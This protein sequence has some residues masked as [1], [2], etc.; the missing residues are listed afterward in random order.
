VAERG[1]GARR[2]TRGA[3][4]AI[5]VVDASIWISSLVEWDEHH[6][7]CDRWLYSQLAAEEAIVLP[8]LALAEIAGAVARRTGNSERG[9]RAVM[10]VLD[11]PGVRIVDLTERL[12]Y[13]AATLAAQYS[14]RG[15]DAVY[16]ATAQL[17]SAPLATTDRELAFRVGSYVAVVQP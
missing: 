15:A 5:V 9:C 17:V 4:R 14:I 6:E 13:T 12:A 7:L 16:V 2:D 10:K 1:H 8:S 3:T 11:I